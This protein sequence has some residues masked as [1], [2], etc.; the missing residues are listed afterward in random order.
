MPLGIFL[1]IGQPKN[2]NKNAMADKAIRELR[3]QLVR[4][5]P[6]GGAV[7]EATLA[8][9]TAFLNSE[10]RNMQVLKVA[11]FECFTTALPTQ[12]DP[13]KSSLCFS[14]TILCPVIFFFLC[15]LLCLKFLRTDS[16]DPHR[17]EQEF[18]FYY[19]II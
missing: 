16:E 13:P 1:V 9:A 6:H 3:E 5:S 2:V 18:L 10:K 8:R 12:T 7:S 11:Q 4:P 14:K 15:R 19:L 17:H